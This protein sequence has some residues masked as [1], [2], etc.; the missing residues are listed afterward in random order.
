MTETRAETGDI[1]V[2]LG[3]FTRYLLGGE[4]YIQPCGEPG[5][6]PSNRP[7]SGRI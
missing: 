7:E 4:D 2:K 3:V 6:A 1:K 5:V